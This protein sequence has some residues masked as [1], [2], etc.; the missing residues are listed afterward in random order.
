[1]CESF[2]TLQKSRSFG[3]GERIQNLV[4]LESRNRLD[5]RKVEFGTHYRGDGEQ[6]LAVDEMEDR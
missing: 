5:N 4:R 3:L 2:A 6:F 1:M